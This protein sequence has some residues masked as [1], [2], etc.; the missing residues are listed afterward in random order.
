M[1]TNSLLSS[2]E[3]VFSQVEGHRVIVF[4]RASPYH[5]GA[6]RLKRLRLIR[7]LTELAG[8]WLFVKERLDLA[9]LVGADGLHLGENAPP[10]DEYRAFPLRLSRAC[11]DEKGLNAA[12]ADMMTLSPVFD[13]ISKT[14]TAILGIQ[15]FRDLVKGKG[16]RVYALGGIRPSLVGELRAAGAS[17]FASLGGVFFADDPGAS[18]KALVDAWDLA[19]PGRPS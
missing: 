4:D 5:A 13:P 6:E 19:S 3:L 8:A 11:H 2:L 16:R 14:A 7:R 12:H 9:L 18:A 15:G 10:A 1:D 17:G